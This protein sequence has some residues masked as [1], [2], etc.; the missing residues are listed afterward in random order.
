MEQPPLIESTPAP[1]VLEKKRYHDLDALR[2]CAMLLGIV[3]HG[4]IAFGEPGWE[5]YAPQNDA[6]WDVPAVITNAAAA[7][8]AEAP[9]KF[10]P[11][12]FCST[13]IHGFRMPL[14]FLVSVFFTAIL[15][16]TRGT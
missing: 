8:G 7:V 16:R 3:L 12:K 11:Y 5:G 1:P 13:A 9:E 2:A 10:S 14:F 4:I 6:H 15:W